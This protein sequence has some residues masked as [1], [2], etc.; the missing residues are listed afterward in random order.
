M[1]G[2][3]RRAWLVPTLVA[4]TA[5]ALSSRAHAAP[6]DETISA[7]PLLVIANGGFGHYY[8]EILLA[9]GLNEFSVTDLAQV[10]PDSLVGREVVILG[11]GTLGADQ[12]DMLRAWVEAGGNLIAMR[13]D[14]SLASLLGLRARTGTLSEGWMAVTPGGPGDGIT[15]LSMQIHGEADMDPLVDAR[16]VATL[17]TGPSTP[18]GWPAVTLR[19]V[20]A[21]GGHAAAFTYDL[22]RSVVLTRQGNPAW[23]GHER[24]GIGPLR[25]DEL[26]FGPAALDPEPDWVS[27]AR[28]AVPQADEQ[29]RLLAN[30]ILAMEGARRPLPRFWYLPKRLKAAIVMTGD[31]HAHGGTIGRFNQ[32]LAGSPPGCSVDDWECIRSTSFIYPNTPMNSLQAATLTAKGFEIGVHLNTR[33]NSLAPDSL[34]HVF[35][36]QLSQLALRFPGIPVSPSQRIHCVAWSG[37]A[38][39]PQ[40]ERAH[41]IRL[42]CTYY[43]W[44]AEWVS[45][46]PGVFTGS[47]FP[48]RFAD[49]DGTLI[50]VYQC[51]TQ[52]TDESGQLYPLTAEALLDKALGA[53]GYYGTFCANMHTDYAASPQSDAIVT[54][55]TTR[56]VPVI[57][58][59]QLLTWL[60]E[61]NSASFTDFSAAGDTVGF[62]IAA[63][64]GARN[65]TA[66]LPAGADAG[67]ELAALA[68]NGA[69]VAFSTETIKGVS[70]AFFDG[71]PGTY[72]AIYDSVG[73]TPLINSLASAPTAEGY[74]AVTWSTSQECDTRLDFGTGPGALDQHVTL[75]G[76]ALDHHVTLTRL[77]PGVT[78]YYRARGLNVAGASVLM[79]PPDQPPD[80][81]V[82]P[83]HTCLLDQGL[84]QFTAGALD[85][86]ASLA[87]IGAGEVTLRPTL[88]WD[89]SGNAL[90][91]GWSQSALESAG[92]VSVAAGVLHVDGAVARS[93]DVLATGQSL[94]LSASV[95]PV[96]GEALGLAGGSEAPPYAMFRTTP[97][98]L[99]ASVC[100][101]VSCL[102]STIAGDWFGI[103]HRFRISWDAQ[104]FTFSIDDL[105]VASLALAVADSMHPLARDSAVAGGVLLVDWMRASPYDSVGTFD[106]R[107]WDAGGPTSWGATTWSAERPSGTALAI[108]VRGGGVP[109]PDSTWTPWVPVD[110]SGASTPLLSE[111]VQYRAVLST[112]DPARTPALQGLA[113]QCNQP[114]AVERGAPRLTALAPPWPNPAAEEVRISGAIGRDAAPGGHIAISCVVMDLAGRRVRQLEHG[115]RAAGPFDLR[116]DRRDDAGRP[117]APG[118]YLVRLRAGA[119]QR[120]AKLTVLR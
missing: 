6:R 36:D 101:G 41:G 96:A 43:Y 63:P 42:D 31:D 51:A 74:T 19:D 113:I 52:M 94:E 115:A 4:F 105:P 84:V 119:I 90:P 75:A 73:A 85:S 18:T 45:G 114:V 81:L 55:A 100:D 103:S 64:N 57:A 48:M 111:F 68:R 80:S 15:P 10:T 13:P 59:R 24:D 50:D 109:A 33:C 54:A 17:M 97:D 104:G 30:L 11:E 88:G 102:D 108:L 107:V 77:V 78:Y 82:A 86:A 56:G 32:Y 87:A 99:I 67:H 29:Q 28:I 91:T 8:G 22:A 66:M 9:E 5:L 47:G 106:S 26:F 61:R 16:L 120:T 89:F 37:W 60:D 110:S 70:Y 98:G 44:P 53:E 93:A 3:R 12:A 39:T 1:V 65:L 49:L 116:W 46:R 76:F 38:I 95:P 21:H 23:V 7:P 117:V 62:A 83:G 40:V 118:I 92:T 2:R 14:T 25:T 58:A 72:R 69:P 27:P 79:P 71:A 35:G 112:V 20:G 34:G